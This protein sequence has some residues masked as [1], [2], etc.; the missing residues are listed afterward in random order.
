MCAKKEKTKRVRKV[1]LIY[2]NWCWRTY[3]INRLLVFLLIFYGLQSILGFAF[4]KKND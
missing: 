2:V 4:D 3:R 1:F